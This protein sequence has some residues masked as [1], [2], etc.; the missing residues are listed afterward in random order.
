MI[1]SSVSRGALWFT[2]HRSMLHVVLETDTLPAA[3]Q[4]PDGWEESCWFKTA[5]VGEGSPRECLTHSVTPAVPWPE[6]HC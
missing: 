3:D 5:S 4:S 6:S 2:G 1:Y